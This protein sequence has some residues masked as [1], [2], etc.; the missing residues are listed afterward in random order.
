M[1]RIKITFFDI[2]MF[3]Q[4]HDFEWNKEKKL[5]KQN[6]TKQKNPLK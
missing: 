3:V 6:K 2:I 4:T 1:L 5:K